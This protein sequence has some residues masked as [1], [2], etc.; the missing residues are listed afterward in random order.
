MAWGERVQRDKGAEEE[1][2]RR[3]EERRGEVRR[4]GEENSGGGELCVINTEWSYSRQKQ[5]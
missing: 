5:L 1:R 3:K 2:R 4:R